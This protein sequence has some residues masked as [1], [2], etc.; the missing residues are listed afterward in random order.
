MAKAKASVPA[1][2][3]A[4]QVS[5]GTT[6]SAVKSGI[7]KVWNDIP[8]WAR[9]VIIV[10]L[11]LIV[12]LI[13]WKLYKKFFGKDASEQ[14]SAE[15]DVRDTQSDLNT[16]IQQGVKPSYQQGQYSQWADSIKT[17]FNGCGT[18]YSTIERI[19]NQMKNKADIM[20]LSA[21]FGVRKWDGCNWEGDF[22]D[23]EGTLAGGL[24]NEL[25]SGE[26]EKLNNILKSKNI[27]YTF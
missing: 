16:L 5:S 8:A 9:G 3:S 7:G 4:P 24:T 19:F 10:L 17:A 11:A 25:S 1:V 6:S 2:S 22:G 27:N 23:T 18:T 21:T 26:V 14:W 20:A 15:E 12:F 13:V